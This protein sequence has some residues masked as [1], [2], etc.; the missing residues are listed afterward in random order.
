M[1][2]DHH[3]TVM[4]GVID[5]LK[6]AGARDD[7]IAVLTP[8]KGQLMMIRNLGLRNNTAITIDTA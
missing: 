4:P 8:Y 5:R 6:Q 3:L 2:P 7:Q 1:S